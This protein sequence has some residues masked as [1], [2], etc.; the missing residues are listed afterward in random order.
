[1]ISGRHR[2]MLQ[3]H[4]KGLLVVL[5][6]LAVLLAIYE[7]RVQIGA[8]NVAYQMDQLMA[9]QQK[10]IDH[11][12]NDPRA[13]LKIDATISPDVSINGS[14]LPFHRVDI[15]V[16]NVS[17]KALFARIPNLAL[18]NGYTSSKTK[19]DGEFYA[20]NYKCL[21]ESGTTHWNDD[22]IRVNREISN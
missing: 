1:M 18:S 9:E 4:R 3:K 17:N 2:G 8:A 14:G 19:A 6:V 7:I 5:G 12:V 11:T 10:I 13:P 20:I 22:F 15:R 16:T 21:Y